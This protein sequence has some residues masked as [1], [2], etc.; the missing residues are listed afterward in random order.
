M[1][2]MG[3]MGVREVGVE[4]E[5]KEE[6]KT[7]EKKTLHQRHLLGSRQGKQEQRPWLFCQRS[8]DRC[9]SVGTQGGGFGG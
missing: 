9:W 8:E 3:D 6:R 5:E 7:E 1:G 4:R 2:R